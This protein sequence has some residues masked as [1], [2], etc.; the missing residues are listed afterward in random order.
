MA[1]K[2]RALAFFCFIS[3]IC[4]GTKVTITKDGGN[5]KPRFFTASKRWSRSVKRSTLWSFLE[6]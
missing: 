6:I 5:L 3:P 4:I 2:V 1:K